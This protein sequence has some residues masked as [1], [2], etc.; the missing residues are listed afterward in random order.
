[1]VEI[2]VNFFPLSR[3]SVNPPLW[4][5]ISQDDSR[6][7]FKFQLDTKL[8]QATNGVVAGEQ[9]ILQ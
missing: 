9:Y 5:Y 1:M 3:L 2:E 6:F 4:I 8:V 7:I